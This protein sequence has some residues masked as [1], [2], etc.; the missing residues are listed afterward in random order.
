MPEKPWK[1]KPYKLCEMRVEIAGTEHWMPVEPMSYPVAARV[2]GENSVDLVRHHSTVCPP[3]GSEFYRDRTVTLGEATMT[4]VRTWP[5]KSWSA[6][7]VPT[8][9]LRKPVIATGTRSDPRSAAAGG[10]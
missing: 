6:V 3:V 9:M 4:L 10:A 8:E 5:G 7:W 1:P 2:M